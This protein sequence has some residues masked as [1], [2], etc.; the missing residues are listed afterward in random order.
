MINKKMIRNIVLAVVVIGLLLAALIFVNKMPD[1][2]SSNQTDI[3]EEN[4]FSDN[5]IAEDIKV[6]DIN[7]EDVSEITIKNK[8]MTYT[9][10]R[11]DAETFELKNSGGIPY[12]SAL[13]SGSFNSFLKINAQR[14]VTEE[15][16][17]FIERARATLHMK[18]GSEKIIIL[19]NEVIGHTNQ[20]FLK[21][22]DKIYAVLSYVSTYFTAHSDSFREKNLANIGSDIKSVMVKKDGVDYVGFKKAENEEEANLLDVATSFVMTYP[23]TMAVH[24]DRLTPLYELFKESAT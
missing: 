5:S 15:N 19:G 23:K 3:S 24:E 14:E 10:A 16:I 7:E 20:H 8:G 4:D 18:D 22:E 17:E 21:Y 12:S 13:L 1:R 9:V 2:D 11:K 6:V